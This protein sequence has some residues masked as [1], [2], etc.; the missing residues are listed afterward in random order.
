MYYQIIAYI[1]DSVRLYSQQK[2]I[3][4]D[5]NM[6][7]RDGVSFCMSA[8]TAPFLST[9]STQA[10]REFEVN[11]MQFVIASSQACC[12]SVIKLQ[13]PTLYSLKLLIVN[14]VGHSSEHNIVSEHGNEHNSIVSQLGRIYRKKTWHCNAA[15][16]FFTQFFSV[17]LSV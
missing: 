10:S 14:L 11:D 6:F 9:S 2:S 8:L 15:L 5:H 17:C 3:S 4:I 7:L 13:Q 1:H 12:G 16:L